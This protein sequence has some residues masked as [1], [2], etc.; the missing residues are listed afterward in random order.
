[1]QCFA[2]SAT[3]DAT[4]A[5]HRYAYTEPNFNDYPKTGVWSDG[6]YTTYNMFG[7]KFV[8]GRACAYDG[9]AMRAGTAAT[10][11]CFQLSASYGGLLPAD[12]DTPASLPASGSPNYIVNFGTNSLNVWKFHPNFTTPASSTFTGPT[13]L[14]VAAFTAACGGGACIPQPGTTQLLDSLADR[15]MYRLAYSKISG[16]ESLV[17]NHT[18]KVGGNKRAEIDGVRWYEIRL[19]GGVPSIYQQG[20]F[21]PSDGSSRWMGSIA[22]DKAGDIALGYSVSSASLDPSIR[23]TG[24]IPGD[25]LGTMEA[26]TSIYSGTGAQGKSLNRWGDYSNLS[27]DPVDGCTMWYTQEFLKTNGTFNW[28]T[29]IGSFKFPSC[30]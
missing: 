23:Y 16:Q 29:R 30:N 17:V 9:A 25:A 27:L 19:S 26:E 6:Y 2:V 18:V 21:A 11:V 8:G 22:R 4:G 1:M 13:T 12:I 7:G 10:E 3:S 28:S 15:L 24:R 5:W 20:T 14:A